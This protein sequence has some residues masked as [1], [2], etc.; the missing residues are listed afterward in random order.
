MTRH[1]F[2]ILIITIYHCHKAVFCNNY[3]FYILFIYTQYF[4]LV[5]SKKQLIKYYK[6]VSYQLLYRCKSSSH[7]LTIVSVLVL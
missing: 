6:S 4:L 1:K 5:K 2:G 3:L 7:C